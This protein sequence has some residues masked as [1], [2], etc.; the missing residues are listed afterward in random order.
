M[1]FC[2]GAVRARYGNKFLI[3]QQNRR[4]VFSI[5][6]TVYCFR[7]AATVYCFRIAATV[8]CFRIAATVYCFRI[9]ADFSPTHLFI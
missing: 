2:A 7:I 1:L 5:A 8:Y 3:F 4:P 9:A 6:A